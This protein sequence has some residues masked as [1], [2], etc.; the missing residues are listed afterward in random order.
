MTTEIAPGTFAIRADFDGVQLTV[1]A[2][3]GDRPALIDTGVATTPAEHLSPALA[4]LGSGLS[5]VDL[6]VNTHAHHDHVGGNAA[7]RAASPDVRIAVH[8]ADADWAQSAE[9]YFA[10]LYRPWDPGPD[11]ERRVLRLF[12]PGAAVDVRLND[13][14]EIDLASDRRLRVRWTPAHSP[15]HVVL[16]DGDIV[17]AGD[18][19][20]R[21]GTGIEGRGWLFPFYTDVD[22]YRA[23]LQA[24]AA[25][26][27]ACTAHFG[28]VAGA[29]LARLIADSEELIET[30]DEL[31]AG[32]LRERGSLTLAEIADVLL[33][34][35]PHYQRGVQVY[36][37]PR[38]H[39]DALV[40]TGRA[41]AVEQR[42]EAR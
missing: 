31:I 6:I 13:G 8:V 42:W 2:L 24:V 34:R 17:F 22:A 21:Y 11:F 39:L 25:A 28:P 33:D 4:S 27:T 37:T 18:A 40:E 29:E 16:H 23:S 38:A 26:G 30:L 35:W 15:G 41:R 5:D 20:Q 9:R 14:D 32:L 7:V 19:I 1:Y 12:G 10:A 3:I 36:A